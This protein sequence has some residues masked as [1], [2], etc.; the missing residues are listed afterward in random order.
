MNAASIVVLGA[1]PAGAAVARALVGMGYRVQV[2][3]DWRRF[4]AAETLSARG[5]EALRRAGLHCAASCGEGPCVRTTLWNGALRTLD[6]EFLVDRRVFDAALREDL[7]SAGMDVIEANVRS[8]Q[9][10]SAGHDLM[11]ET[12]DGPLTLRADFLVE[13]RGRLAPL[14]RD[15]TRGPQTVSLLNAWAGSPGAA[16]TAV[17][18]LP[19][20]WAWMARLN[21]GRCYWQ[22]TLD[23]ANPELPQRDELL[24]FCERMRHSPLAVDFFSGDDA[25]DARL[26]AR[27]STATLCGRTG[28]HNW[29]RVGDAAMA[30]DPLASN[31]VFQSLTSALQ[32]PAVIHTL[33]ARPDR[34]PLALRF[35]QQRIEQLF[36]RFARTSRDVYALEQRWSTQPFWQTR[37]AWPDDRPAHVSADFNELNV[38]RAPVI[39]GGMIAEADVVASPDQPLGIWH[40]CDAALAPVVEAL[41]REPAE[42]VLKSLDADQAR[43]IRHWLAMQDFPE[44]YV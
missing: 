35:H 21:D 7:C 1:G 40:L 25:K 32:A 24:A 22:L 29:L 2:V 6:A 34:A 27:S 5:I 31:G 33:L 38:G 10:T 17:E 4:D 19:A 42:Q 16:A 28:G 37:S 9:S 20:G 43:L 11:I 8:L 18:S 26:Y 44:R 23:V 15:A 13:A 3:S 41:R 39:E 12:A 30:V 36:T 14:L